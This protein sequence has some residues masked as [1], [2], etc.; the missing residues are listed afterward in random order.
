MRESQSRVEHQLCVKAA[1]GDEKLRE[2]NAKGGVALLWRTLDA[3]GFGYPW[4][5]D[6]DMNP[7]RDRA[8]FKAVFAEFEKQSALNR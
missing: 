3:K 7:I 4:R 1:K 6:A 8:D 2:E 5:K